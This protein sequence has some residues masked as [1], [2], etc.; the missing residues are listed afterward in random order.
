M[1]R[2][3]QEADTPASQDRDEG[4][5]DAWR[6][7]PWWLRSLL[8]ITSLGTLSIALRPMPRL[9]DY[10]F[11]ED[12]YYAFSVSRNL[13]VGNGLTIDGE[14]WTNG[15]QPLFT[16][17]TSVAFLGS[18]PEEIS[19]RL[20]MIMQWGVL[21]ATAMVVGLIVRTYTGG[22]NTRP[23]AFGVGFL[24][25]IGSFYVIN[26]SLNGLETGTLLLAYAVAWRY[27]QLHPPIN[28]KAAATLGV[29][30]GVIA[31][32]RIDALVVIGVALL[33]IW[34]IY[35]FTRA[36]LA[37]A[38]TLFVVL[39]WLVYGMFLTGSPI[40]SSGRAQTLVELSSFRAER[41]LDALTSTG[42]PWLPITTLIPNYGTAVRGLLL[43]ALLI[44]FMLLRR[45][46]RFAKMPRTEVF[47]MWLV[48]GV[49]AL[50]GY[51]AITSYAY[52]FY[53][54]YLAPLAL[55]AAVLVAAALLWLPRVF[56]IFASA[57]LTVTALAASAGHW[58]TGLY[59]ENTMF[60]AQV[61]LVE[62]TVPASETVSAAQTGTLGFFRAKTLNLDGKVNAD[63]LDFPGTADEYLK[64][65]NVMWMCD[66]PRLI[67]E[68]LGAGHPG[69]QEVDSQDEYLC[70]RRN[71]SSSSAQ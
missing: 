29:L 46:Q 12:A 60:T 26:T 62:R 1:T 66:W 69:W 28:P 33:G 71:P 64:Q 49:L 45:Q 27:F 11:I 18:P 36:A 50:A 53:G 61:A 7:T 57:A 30:L 55:V 9:L 47:G 4:L 3:T 52:W 16:F 21:V 17:L 8:I 56:S 20:I 23:L 54:R 32:V 58:V 6:L 44:V 24:A 63:I 40:P 39:P 42:L 37:G 65:A 38:V 5:L 41:V 15:F 67:E 2:G 14:T 68:Y 48:V 59:Q 31:L 43:A 19:L 25:Y 51:Y 13:A 34:A 70:V 22:G 35:G 10:P